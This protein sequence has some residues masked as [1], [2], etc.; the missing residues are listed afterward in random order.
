MG[1]ITDQQIRQTTKKPISKEDIA[2]DVIDDIDTETKQSL[3]K[4]G[5]TSVDDLKN[6]ENKNI[7]IEKVSKKKVNYKRLADLIQKNR[8][9]GLAPRVNAVSMSQGKDG[10]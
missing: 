6:I 4:M 10:R 3:R 9:K 1:S 2:I 8:R 7:D 5:V